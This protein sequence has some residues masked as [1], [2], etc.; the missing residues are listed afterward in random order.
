MPDY[1]AGN[2]RLRDSIGTRLITL[3]KSL[4]FKV[5][6]ILEH[7]AGEVEDYAQ[8]NA[9]WE[10]RT[11]EARAGLTATVQEDRGDLELVLYNDSEHGIWLEIAMSQQFEIIMPT[12]DKYGPEIMAALAA[13]I[14]T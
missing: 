1:A 9:P 13:G 8:S 5:R 10:D 14:L 11:G 4:Q 2:I 3:E 6:E 7:Y 12:L